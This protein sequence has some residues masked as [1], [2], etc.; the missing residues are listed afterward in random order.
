VTA[1]PARI[2]KTVIDLPSGASFSVRVAR[3]ED[4]SIVTALIHD[5]FSIW[6]DEGL[7]LGPMHQTDEQTAEHLVG[8]G[9]VAEN[10]RGGLWGTFSLDEGSIR[11]IGKT[12]IS[13][14]EGTEA[15]DY[16]LIGGSRPPVPSGAL[17]VFKKAAVKRDAANSGLGS[18]LYTLAEKTARSN[19]YS[20]MV[21]ETVKEAAWLYE[22]YLRLGFKP[23]GSYRYP[24]SQVDTILMIK[25]FNTR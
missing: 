20:G 14:T 4:V 11:R 24:G 7:S 25:P 8:K 19:G 13:F 18:K 22:W 23:I 3:A 17:L 15:T 1:G 16:S 5:A 6:K 2:D 10:L 21:I 12:K 9:Y